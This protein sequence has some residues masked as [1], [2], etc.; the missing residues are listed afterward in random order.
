VG[1]DV[2]QR[3]GGRLGARAG[4]AGGVVEDLE[5]EEALRLFGEVEA[6]VGG[7]LAGR[8]QVET[9]SGTMPEAPA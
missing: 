1:V 8:P 2:D 3:G 9:M 5:G 4:G 7:V 6:A